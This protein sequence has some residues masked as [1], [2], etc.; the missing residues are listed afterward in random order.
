MIKYDD[1]LVTFTE[2]PDECSLCFNITNCPCHCVDCFE[3]WLQK[4]IGVELNIEVIK[5]LLAENKYCTC[6]C[7]MGGDANHTALSL[8]IAQCREIWPHIKF[9]M[10]SGL[11]LMDD[12]LA[13]QLDYY[14]VGPFIPERGPLNKTTTNQHMYKK[15]DGEWKDITYRFYDKTE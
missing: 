8:L 11:P 12:A 14:K 2:V 5:V 3:P 10:Y 7:F 1:Y 4:D 9:A 15:I 6:I 13:K